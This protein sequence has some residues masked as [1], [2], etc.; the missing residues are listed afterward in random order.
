MINATSGGSESPGLKIN[1][2]LLV[3]ASRYD[4]KQTTLIS[5][6]TTLN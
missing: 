5:L 2:T 3:V 4:I 1:N 6:A